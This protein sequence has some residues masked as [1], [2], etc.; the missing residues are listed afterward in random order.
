MNGDIRGMLQRAEIE[1]N[2]NILGCRPVA[3]DSLPRFWM[4]RVC[5]YTGGWGRI[6][7]TTGM[8]WLESMQPFRLFDHWGKSTTIDGRMCFVTEP[9][10]SFRNPKVIRC[11][12]ALAIALGL[13]LTVYDEDQSWWYP[14]H[15]M[16]AEFFECN[17]TPK[18]S[19][20]RSEQE[21]RAMCREQLRDL[22]ASAKTST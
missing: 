10:L 16:R 2:R 15:T 21:H 20:S 9:Y 8:N 17:H 12:A 13:D 3:L 6:A 7:A 22:I 19:H 11:Y 5:R 4:A 14:G 18:C 1:F